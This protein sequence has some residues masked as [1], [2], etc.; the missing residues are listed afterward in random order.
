[1]LQG[2]K[3]A[4]DL[5]TA[6]L[7]SRTHFDGTVGP[8]AGWPAQVLGGLLRFGCGPNPGDVVTTLQHNMINLLDD[9]PLAVTTVG[10]VP[11]VVWVLTQ[12]RELPAAQQLVERSAHILGDSPEITLSRAMLADAANKPKSVL[13]VLASLPEAE[14]TGPVTAVFRWLLL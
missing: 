9:Y 2:D 1:Y 7:A 13:A 8:A 5:V 6:A 10:L 11:P 12:T 3:P 14:R 4:P